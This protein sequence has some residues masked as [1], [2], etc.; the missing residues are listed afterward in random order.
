[1]KNKV[2]LMLMETIV[3]KFKY[4]IIVIL[5][6][7]CNN[8]SEDRE[9]DALKIY[10]SELKNN[11]NID[12]LQL[13]S[14]NSNNLIFSR[15]KQFLKLED[16]I[17]EKTPKI[18]REV[19]SITERNNY[20]NQKVENSKWNLGNQFLDIEF[21]NNDSSKEKLVVSKPIFSENSKYFMVYSLSLKKDTNNKK[22]Y[23]MPPIQVYKKENKIWNKVYTIPSMMFNNIND[24]NLNRL[25]DNIVDE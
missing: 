1:M 9:I 4:L 25:H 15:Y 12:I 22:I 6:V 17:K 21:D 2:T 14:D 10:F 24:N 19:F 23:F 7:S 13:S 16:S 5:I 18:L 8:R 3:N 11:L 20:L